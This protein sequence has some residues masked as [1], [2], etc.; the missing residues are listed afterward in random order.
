MNGP[1]NNATY[2]CPVDCK[3]TKGNANCPEC[4]QPM[5]YMGKRWRAPKLN[6]EAA[7][8]RVQS[9]DILWELPAREDPPRLLGWERSQKKTGSDIPK[10]H[11]TPIF[12]KPRKDRN[13]E[14][15]EEILRRMNDLSEAT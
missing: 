11:P 6:N 12:Y 15:R 9:G 13:E 7:W 4:S 5:I 10:W 2:L 14:I 3:V 1:G 8:R